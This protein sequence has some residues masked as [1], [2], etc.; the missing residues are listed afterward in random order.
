MWLS[1]H[2][3]TLSLSTWDLFLEPFCGSPLQHLIFQKKNPKLVNT[4]TESFLVCQGGL[5][6]LL[7]FF[8][9][10]GIQR[11]AGNSRERNWK[12]FL[13]LTSK[14]F[15]LTQSVCCQQKH[16]C[17]RKADILNNT[18]ECISQNGIVVCNWSI[19]SRGLIIECID[20]RLI[21]VDTSILFGQEEKCLV[22]H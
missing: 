9:A 3:H 7:G 16:Q 20:L 2:T 10:S 4:L 19:Y 21:A 12:G 11:R 6:F 17:C 15:C 5:S 14:A 22:C 8:W 13:V 1:W 18:K